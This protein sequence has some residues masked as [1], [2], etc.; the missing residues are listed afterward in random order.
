MGTPGEV[1][2]A[3]RR[4]NTHRSIAGIIKKTVVFKAV[5]AS[6]KDSQSSQTLIFLFNN[7]TLIAYVSTFPHIHMLCLYLHCL[8]VDSQQQV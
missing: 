4:M 7:Q 5:I 3:A 2:V 1:A 6:L 8:Q